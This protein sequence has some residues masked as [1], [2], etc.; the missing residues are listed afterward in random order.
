MAKDF[1]NIDPTQSAA[2]Q[3]RKLISYI[4]AQRSAYNL[5]AEV[6]GIMGHNND[7]I[8]FSKIEVLF[9][10]PPGKGQ[11]VFDL[12]NGSWGAMNGTFKVSDA[13]TITEQ[14]G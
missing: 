12:V 13:K 2:T 11:A 3:A 8:D 14:V 6:I 10:L 9:G 1:I 5:G 7:G 4:N